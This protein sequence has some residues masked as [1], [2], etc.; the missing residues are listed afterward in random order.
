MRYHD[1]DAGE[2]R[3]P[4]LLSQHGVLTAAVGLAAALCHGSTGQLTSAESQA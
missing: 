4:K 2:E 1:E 3:S